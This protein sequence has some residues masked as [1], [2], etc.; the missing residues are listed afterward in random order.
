MFR[1]VIVFA[2]VVVLANGQLRAQTLAPHQ[3]TEGRQKASRTEEIL[4]DAA[5]ALLIV[6]ASI[7]TYKATGKPC[8]CPEDTMRN[9][10]KCGANSAW[11]RPGGYK[12]LCYPTEI[13]AAMIA[14]YRATRAVPGLR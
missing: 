6:A 14:A 9:G 5:V 13:S 8:A 3:G 7:A 11:S 1:R 10:R 2:L 4:T 12:P